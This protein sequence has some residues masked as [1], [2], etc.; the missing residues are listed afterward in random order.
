[1]WLGCCICNLCLLVSFMRVFLYLVFVFNSICAFTFQLHMFSNFTNY[2]R[3]VL[4]EQNQQ[5]SNSFYFRIYVLVLGVYAAVRVVFALLLKFP[6]CHTLSAMSDQSF[7]Q[8]F[9]WIYQV[10]TYILC[11]LIFLKKKYWP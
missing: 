6:A 3:K 10:Y 7:F 9:K 5:N 4:E 8:F 11:S 1:M 2:C